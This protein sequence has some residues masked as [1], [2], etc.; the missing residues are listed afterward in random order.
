VDELQM[1]PRSVVRGHWKKKLVSIR[2]KL[3]GPMHYK[4]YVIC[5]YKWTRVLYSVVITWQSNQ[6]ISQ[7]NSPCNEFTSDWSMFVYN[8]HTQ[9]T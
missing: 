4:L 1:F 9:C 5:V 8:T 2:N 6:P 3:Y 7:Y